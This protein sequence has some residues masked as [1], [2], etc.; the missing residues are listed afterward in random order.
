MYTCKHACIWYHCAVTLA[1]SKLHSL[2]Q[3]HTHTHTHEVPFCDSLLSNYISMLYSHTYMQRERE[4][5]REREPL[6][7]SIPAAP[8]IHTCMHTYIHTYVFTCTVPFCDSIPIERAVFPAW[9]HEAPVASN[10]C[11]TIEEG[12][13]CVGLCVCV[14]VWYACIVA[15]VCGFMRH[16][17]LLSTYMHV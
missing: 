3:T 13:V 5:E 6:C 11:V 9:I 10:A 1:Q 7:D 12:N 16:L 14:C 8:C 17:L 15:L 2:S 4:R